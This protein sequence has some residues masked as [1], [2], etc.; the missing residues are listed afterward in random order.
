MTPAMTDREAWV[1]FAAAKL[2]AMVARS[3]VTDEPSPGAYAAREAADWA[4]A[5]LA[6]YRKRWPEKDPDHD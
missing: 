2:P 5:L 4:D 1:A 3:L 6:E